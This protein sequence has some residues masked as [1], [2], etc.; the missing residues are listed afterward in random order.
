LFPYTTLFR[1]DDALEVQRLDRLGEGLAL[2]GVGLLDGRGDH[3]HRDVG[4]RAED[5]GALVVLRLVGVEELLGLGVGVAVVDRGQRDDLV[6]G[7][8]GG[9][10]DGR[11]GEGQVP[12]DVAV[13]AGVH[14]GLQQQGVGGAS[15]A[16]QEDRVRLG[17][18][19]LAGLRGEV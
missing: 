14:H 7:G 2:V 12:D 18:G 3:L 9:V 11:G 10:R 13:E 16:V 8:A 1:S 19:G 4:V 17:G 15:A 6:G 5:R